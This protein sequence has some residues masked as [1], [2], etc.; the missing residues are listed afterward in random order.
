MEAGFTPLLLNDNDKTCCKILEENHPGVDVFCGSM[1]KL[2]VSGYSPDLLVG[3]MPCQSFSQA[4]KRKGLDD[5][6][7]QLILEFKRLIDECHPK[8]FLIENVKGLTTHDKGATLSHIIDYLSEGGEY[9]IQQQVLNAVD[10]SVPQ[11][12]ERLIIVGVRKN[13]K[14]KFIYPKRHSHKLVLSDVLY[15]VPDSEGYEY[16]QSKKDVLDLVPPGGCWV[17]LP[18][19]I[20][21]SYMGASYNSSGGKK[22]IARRLSMDEP[23]LTL[24]TSPMQKQ[25]ER[26]HPLETRQFT[27]REYARIQ[28]FPDNYVF[29][30]SLA[31]KYKQ[32]GNAVPVE[33]ARNIGLSI[34]D[35]L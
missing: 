15:D 30:G 33:L 4:G 32:I 27:V 34:I 24:T 26:C 22:G 1:A 6:R 14:N 10:Y 8:V 9:V 18:E 20:Q 11:K 7:G 21:L 28:T 3:G 5:D 31:N 16:P 2:D 25:T 12:R 17:N 35:V 19:D 23:S 29:T 13:I